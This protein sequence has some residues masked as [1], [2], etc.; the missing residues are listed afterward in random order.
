VDTY[1]AK[2]LRR[3]VKHQFDATVEVEG[4]V[5]CDETVISLAA[6]VPCCY[7]HTTVSRQERKTRMVTERSSDGRSYSREETYYEWTVDLNETSS[8]IFKVHDKTGHTLVD[9]TKARIDLETVYD[10]QVPHRESWF[11]K[12]VGHSDTGLYKVLEQAF[13]PK[14]NAYVLGRATDTED[15]VALIRLPEKG[16]MDPKKKFFV[17]SRKNEKEL[18]RSKQKKARWLFWLSVAFFSIAVYCLFAYFK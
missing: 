11:E 7:V 18:T 6:R 16:Y 5:T 14:G 10:E 15:G 12:S 2:D 8:V 17:I 4:A 3:L 1:T 9:P 13:L